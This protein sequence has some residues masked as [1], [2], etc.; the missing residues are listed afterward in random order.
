MRSR[1]VHLGSVAAI[2]ALLAVTAVGL[3]L[4]DRAPVDRAYELQQQLRCPVCTSVSIAES[5]SDTAVAMRRAVD[6]QI[7]AGRSNTEIIDY[8]RARYGDWVLLDPPARG[9]TTLLWLLPA[10]AALLGL[11]AVAARARRAPPPTT[12]LSPGDRERV[13]AAVDRARSRPAE[14]EP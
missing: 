13:A 9:R 1:L 10:G 8:F 14:E 6:E 12:E 11:A 4:G 3:L 2:V 5:Q 7:A